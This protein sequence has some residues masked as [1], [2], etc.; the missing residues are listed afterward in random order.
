MSVPIVLTSDG[1][2][3]TNYFSDN[4]KVVED[5]EIALTKASVSIPVVAQQL[6]RI[7]FVG[8]GGALLSDNAFR[9]MLDGLER[10]I[11]W[12][13]FHQAYN[14]LNTD[15]GGL[16]TIPLAQF[17]SGDYEI[18]MNNNIVLEDIATGGTYGLPTISGILARAL[19]LKYQFFDAREAPPIKFSKINTLN[20]VV[21]FNG[22][23]YN[24]NMANCKNDL[25]IQIEYEPSSVGNTSNV[26]STQMVNL[27][28]TTIAGTPADI[29]INGAGGVFPN[30]AAAA[31]FFDTTNGNSRVDCNGGYFQFKLDT[32]VSGT[33][34]IG[35]ANAGGAGF[36]ARAASFDCS[37]M[38]FGALFEFID[39][40]NDNV[41]TIDGGE[42]D[43]A[44]GTTQANTL[45]VRDFTGSAPL[46][47]TSGTGTNHYFLRIV[48]GENFYPNGGNFKFELHTNATTGDYKNANTHKIYES[49]S[50]SL[51]PQN[52]AIIV[53]G[54]GVG[55]KVSEC[56][57]IPMLDDSL[58]QINAP[59]PSVLGEPPA[60]PSGL[61]CVSIRPGQVRSQIYEADYDD[62]L[63]DFYNGIG[64]EMVDKLNTRDLGIVNWVRGINDFSYEWKI[65]RDINQAS[66]KYFIGTTD[67]NDILEE[68][69]LVPGLPY[70][71]YKT[72]ALTEIPR[73]IDVK[74]ND[75]TINSMSGSYA[76]GGANY[77]TSSIT[78]DV[79][80]IQ[81]DKEYFEIE[82]NFNLDLQYE[83]FN[84]IYRRLHN[85]GEIP[86]N[87]LQVELSF[88]DFTT[89]KINKIKNI[90]GTLKV[91]VHMKKHN[92]GH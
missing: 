31:S 55:N 24:V 41:Y 48:R 69:E 15:L 35:F 90:N 75:L 17:Y 32:M 21:A 88:K 67:L 73:I 23:N 87:Q 59:S 5:A 8:A 50:V 79:G 18:A 77:Q 82:N 92:C 62:T 27:A 71:A 22:D 58:E 33:M 54:N 53:A 56:K 12:T 78:K 14:S 2:E 60:I 11:S 89:N 64:Y 81:V 74:I 10:G 3:F 49:P 40:T 26:L 52:L 44:V 72:D 30:M 36:V 4:V 84:L 28:N 46:V 38:P 57:Y 45:P 70:L 9:V 66:V 13:E 37:S 91:E 34:A 29:T 16:Y 85:V 42:L 80:T 83:P 39:G 61:N 25:G 7:P 19:T 51:N 76:R 6:V 86:V 65:E 47:G 43:P 63:I 20:G 68:K 1:C